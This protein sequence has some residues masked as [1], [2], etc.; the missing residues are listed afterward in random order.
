MQMGQQ[1]VD[2]WAMVLRIAKWAAQVPLA[3]LVI[4]TAGCFCYLGFYF[5]W[6][7]TMWVFENYLKYPW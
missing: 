6:R 1:R 2:L 7:V 5:V 4:F 3:I